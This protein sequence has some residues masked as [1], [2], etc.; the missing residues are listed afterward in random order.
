[1]VKDVLLFELSL[2]KKY[3]YVM[4]RETLMYLYHREPKSER[5]TYEKKIE[6][7]VMC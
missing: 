2:G 1:M 7:F 3:H 6:L 5:Y 4:D